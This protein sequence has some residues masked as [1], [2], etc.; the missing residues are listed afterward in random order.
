MRRGNRRVRTGNVRA[1]FAKVFPGWV[2][3]SLYDTL[4][5]LDTLASRFSLDCLSNTNVFHEER[6]RV[7]FGLGS[8]LDHAYI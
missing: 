5:L 2:S 1:E 8:Q 4:Q 7:N 6:M 3:E